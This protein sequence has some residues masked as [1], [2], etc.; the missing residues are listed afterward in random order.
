MVTLK[1]QFSSSRLAISYHGLTLLVI[2][3]SSTEQ[4]IKL[5][6]SFLGVLIQFICNNNWEKGKNK[7]ENIDLLKMSQCVCLQVI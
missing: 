1:A 3:Y 6:E 4:R 5:V 2:V 7:E